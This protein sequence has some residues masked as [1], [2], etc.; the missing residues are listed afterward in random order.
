MVVVSPFGLADSEYAGRYGRVTG[1]KRGEHAVVDEVRE[2]VA[3][4]CGVCEKV[5]GWSRPRRACT[6]RLPALDE[7]LLP[8]SILLGGDT[9]THPGRHFARRLCD[10]ECDVVDQWE[11]GSRAVNDPLQ[12]AS[13]KRQRVHRGE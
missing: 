13:R 6:S 11:T 1:G 12:T 4:L 10:H 5:L 7:L 8:A 9:A 3:C 2:A